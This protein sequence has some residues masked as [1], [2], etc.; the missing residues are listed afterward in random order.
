MSLARCINS[1][2]II[3]YYFSFFSPYKHSYKIVHVPGFTFTLYRSRLVLNPPLSEQP[4]P[5]KFCEQAHGSNYQ[6]YGLHQHA[7]LFICSMYS[8]TTY[9]SSKLS[10]HVTKHYMLDS[11]FYGILI[12][13]HTTYNLLVKIMIKI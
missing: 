10:M 1:H 12:L 9:I 4:N 8:L 13:L 6:K 5:Y 3:L 7:I 2:L 11:Y